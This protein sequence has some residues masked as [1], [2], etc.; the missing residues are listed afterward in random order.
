MSIATEIHNF[1]L[2]DELFDQFSEWSITDYEVFCK[3]DNLGFFKRF[4]SSLDFV[5]SWIA[6]QFETEIDNKG[7]K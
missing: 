2:R 5:D 3:V 4:K 6:K 7:S 1:N